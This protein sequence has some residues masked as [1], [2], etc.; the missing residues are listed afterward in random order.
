MKINILI[1]GALYSSQASYSAWQYCLA[2]CEAGHQISQVFFHQ[3]AVA[4]GN[5]L[6]AVMSDEPDMVENWARFAEHY[7][8]PLVICVSSAERRGVLNGALATE[9]AK[10]AANL[11]PSFSIA[12][13]G[14]LTDASITSDRTVSFS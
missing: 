10:T 13:L 1:N 8:V 12:G 5:M 9:H 6:S 3:D 4:H 14:T 2:A 11:H 7:S